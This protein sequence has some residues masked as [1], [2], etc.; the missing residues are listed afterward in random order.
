ML[1]KSRAKNWEIVRIDKQ[2]KPT[3]FAIV[4]QQLLKS[5]SHISFYFILFFLLWTNYQL[6]SINHKTIA[7]EKLKIIV[8]KCHYST[9]HW[10]FDMKVQIF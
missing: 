8:F 7:A 5:F 4:Q 10:G 3:C 2:R 6:L 1:E 9:F